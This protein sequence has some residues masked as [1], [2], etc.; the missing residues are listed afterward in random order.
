MR[1]QLDFSCG[2]GPK[3]TAVVAGGRGA[4]DGFAVCSQAD[5][6]EIYWYRINRVI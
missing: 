6:R 2:V 1:G 3:A 5:D 4:D